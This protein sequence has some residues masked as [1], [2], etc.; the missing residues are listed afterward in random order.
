M[1]HTLTLMLVIA[2]DPGPNSLHTAQN[3]VREALAENAATAMEQL[4]F[5]SGRPMLLSPHDWRGR[6]G[7]SIAIGI[8]VRGGTGHDGGE[9]EK[10]GNHDRGQ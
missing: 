1:L 2:V 10:G 5:D 3:Q 4:L 8:Y 9:G 7:E 6:V